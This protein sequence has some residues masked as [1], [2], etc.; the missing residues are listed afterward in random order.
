MLRFL[1][2]ISV[3]L[4]LA[5]PGF[6]CRKHEEAGTEKIL[7]S[8]ASRG[9][10]RFRVYSDRS[11]LD[12]MDN[13]Q[14]ILQA[15]APES[16]SLVFSKLKADSANYAIVDFAAAAPLHLEGARLLYECRYTLEPMPVEELRIPALKAEFRQGEQRQE[17]QSEEFSLKVHMSEEFKAEQEI[18][19]RSGLPLARSLHRAR[20]ARSWLLTGFLLLALLGGLAYWFWRRRSRAAEP[21]QLE[22]AH[23]KALRALQQLLEQSLLEQGAFKP[24]YQRLSF[25]LRVYIEER[26]QINAP[27]LTSEEFLASLTR[28]DSPLAEKRALLQEFMTHCDLV[29]FAEH[30]PG[31]QEARLSFDY[32]KSFIEQSAEVAETLS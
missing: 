22:P 14:L 1:V 30:Q 11:E 17:L 5:L 13:F 21:L 20:G 6:S 28:E 4:L 16:Q 9:D 8:A 7:Q 29:K 10:L 32:C 12:V 26:Y 19:R 25:I 18:D 24:F 2:Y 27:E 3:C 31:E 15:E 23:L